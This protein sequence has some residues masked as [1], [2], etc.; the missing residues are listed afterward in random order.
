MLPRILFRSSRWTN[1]PEGRRRLVQQGARRSHQLASVEADGRHLTLQSATGLGRIHSLRLWKH[2]AALLDV[3]AGLFRFVR[4]TTDIKRLVDLV[5]LEQDEPRFA[6]TA[7][8]ARAVGPRIP[9]SWKLLL[10]SR[11]HEK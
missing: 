4:T 8:L 11:P 3:R 5:L 6:R 10:F 7:R 1:R 2:S 9:S